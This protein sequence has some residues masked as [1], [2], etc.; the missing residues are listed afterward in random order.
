MKIAIID[1]KLNLKTGGGSNEH[2]HL[3]ASEL[4]KRGCTVEVITLDPALNAYPD[5]LPYPIIEA[6]LFTNSIDKRYR[7]ALLKV[8]QEHE[9][10]YDIYHLWHPEFSA[11]GALYKILGGKVPVIVNLIGYSFCSNLARLDI[12]C[13]RHCGLLQKV[14]HRDENIM[15]KMSLLP[16]HTLEY[17]IEKL[18]L[19]HVDA[20]LPLTDYMADAFSWQNFNKDKMSIIPVPIDYQYWYGQREICKIEPFHN[21]GYNVLY[22]G[23]LTPEKGVD[24]LI[25]AIQRLDFPVHLRIVGDGPQ[26]SELERLTK[27]LNLTDYVTFY[28]WVPHEK[29]A[30]FYLSSQ[31]F[32]HPARW[33]EVFCLSVVEAMAMGMPTIVADYGD[34]AQSLDGA[35]LTFKRADTDDLA[36]KIKL[37]YENPLLAN[38]LA[39]KAQERAKEFDYNKVID[40]LLEVYKN[41][42][43]KK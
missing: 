40:K 34:A 19:N 16:F 3:I 36:E 20:F 43:R 9:K 30:A 14:L 11:Y 33:P 21:G 29:L 42:I 26:R 32:V 22:V 17:H 35:G 39:K 8:L 2:L 24:I 18:I 28:G 23:R 25:K 5:N 41:I 13:Y 27:E 10:K 12:M 37:V 6:G 15:K 4:V 7:L 1:A 31:L 38:S